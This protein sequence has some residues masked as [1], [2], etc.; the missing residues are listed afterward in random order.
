[1]DQSAPAEPSAKPS[2]R[3]VVTW[4]LVIAI[5]VL[6]FLFANL[7]SQ[8]NRGTVDIISRPGNPDVH[9]IKNSD[10]EM[11]QAMGRA[12]SSVKD[13]IAAMKN[14]KPGT[15]AYSVKVHIVDGL[16]SEHMWMD[17]LTYH[18]GKFSGEIS[19]EPNGVTSVKLGDK[20]SVAESEISDWMYLSSDVLVG[21]FTI[22]AIRKTM[23]AEQR[24]S[25]DKSLPFKL[26]Q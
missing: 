24:S 11:A 17:N 3:Q 21:G 1:M 13:F 6:K 4:M 22:L 8:T 20:Y 12:R 14:P 23:S 10:E 7:T 25:F 9:Y 16:S 2:I 18:E 15:Q 5:V 26:P 19:N